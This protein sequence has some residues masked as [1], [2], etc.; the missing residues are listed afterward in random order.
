M[1]VI[2]FGLGVVDVATVAQ[3][4]IPAHGGSLAAGG[5][6]YVAP[7][8]VGVGNDLVA[9][10]VHDGDYV[11]LQIGDVVVEDGP[12]IVD[13]DRL[14]FSIVSEAHFDAVHSQLHQLTT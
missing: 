1:E 2:Q 12:I 11:A 3:G 9:V 10:L 14:A 6:Q 7:S 4:V 13:G 8:I 5:G